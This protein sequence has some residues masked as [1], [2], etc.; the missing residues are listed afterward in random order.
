MPMSPFIRE[1]RSRVGSMRL[2]LPSV[3]GIVRDADGRVLLVRQRD[4]DVWSTPGGAIEPDET[5]GDAVVRE[6]WEETGLHVQPERVLGVY[7]GPELVVRYENGDETQ[8]VMIVFECVVRSGDLRA[9]EEETI[10]ARFWSRGDAVDLRLAD[11]LVNFI[12]VF[13]EPPTG[14]HFSPATWDP[15]AS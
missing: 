7:G 2:L 8:Y 6:V 3:T 14:A 11:W 15:A 4:G 1:L 10:D 13:F 9:D 5:P 12:D